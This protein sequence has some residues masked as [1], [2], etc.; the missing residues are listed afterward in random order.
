MFVANGVG[1]MVGTVITGK[2]LDP[3]YR[4]MKPKVEDSSENIIC[5]EDFPIE[6]AR[7]RLVPFF[8]GLQCLCTLLCGWT[9]I[10]P[11]RPYRF[12]HHFDFITG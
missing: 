12:S 6:R 3:N 2:I 7:H 4:R 9:F 11:P 10:P 1:S 5:Q 8:S